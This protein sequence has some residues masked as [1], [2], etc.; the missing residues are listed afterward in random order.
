MN[1]PGDGNCW[2]YATLMSQ[3]HAENNLNFYEPQLCH[4]EIGDLVKDASRLPF[5]KRKAFFDSIG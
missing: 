5:A 4:K 1:V 2:I 3:F